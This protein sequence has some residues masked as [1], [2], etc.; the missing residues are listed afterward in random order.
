MWRKIFS[1]SD[2]SGPPPSNYYPQEQAPTHPLGKAAAMAFAVETSALKPPKE[3]EWE[4]VFEDRF[5]REE[6]GDGWR[7]TEGKWQIIDGAL[8]GSGWIV[9]TRGFPG[10]D[11]VGFQRMEF[12][13]VTD[14]KAFDVLGTGTDAAPQIGDMSSLL[15]V[16]WA[17]D[18][19]GSPIEKGYFFQFGGFWNTRNMIRKAKQPLV[20]K[21]AP[22]LKIVPGKVH[23]IVVEND[24][25]L[26]RMTVNGET[27]LSHEEDASILGGGHDKVGFYA[28]TAIKVLNV[29]VYVKTLTGG[30]GLE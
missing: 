21:K 30:L 15:H 13:A 3:A 12:E 27:A 6:L 28:H 18:S 7:V 10:G 1:G 9:S 5:D 23:K 4:L 24:G 16:K 29:K 22:A 25:G 8:R 2:A 17:A 26:L 11:E 19:K 14:I 20:E